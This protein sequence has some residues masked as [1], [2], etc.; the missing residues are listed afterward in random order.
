MGCS[1]SFFSLS[2][3]HE[4]SAGL[5]CLQQHKNNCHKHK[6]PPAECPVFKTGKK[7]QSRH[8]LGDTHCEGVEHGTGKTYMSR[9]IHHTYGNQFII[10]KR[11][12]Y[13][14]DNSNK[15]NSLLTHSKNG[16]EQAE[17][18]HYQ[19]YHNPSES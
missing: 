10:A 11:P 13:R 4:M 1:S 16:T 5:P 14:D 3:C 9:D 6:N 17:K 12:C 8:F 7:L 19:H 18:Q 15:G 2:H